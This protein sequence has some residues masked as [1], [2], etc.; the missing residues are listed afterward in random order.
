MDADGIALA[1]VKALEART[2]ELREDNRALREQVEALTKVVS[3]LLA[4]PR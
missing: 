3:A 2:Q 1:A 4:S